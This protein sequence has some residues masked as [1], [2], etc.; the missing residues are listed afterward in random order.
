MDAY[1]ESEQRTGFLTLIA[2]NLALPFETEILGIMVTLERVEFGAAG[3]I[4][5][6]CRHGKKRQAI[7]ILDLPLPCPPPVG[8]KWIAAYR[9]WIR[10][11]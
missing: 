2:D 6:I 8:A 10:G 7:P 3:D 9:C 11:C 1:N 4:V 5:A